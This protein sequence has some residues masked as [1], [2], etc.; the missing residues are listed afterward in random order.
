M[1][2]QRDAIA[3]SARRFDT[4]HH[5]NH[6]IAGRG[7]ALFPRERFG[8][9]YRALERALGSECFRWLNGAAWSPS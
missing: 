5:L 3:P 4:G 2:R 9:E 6:G 1:R 7:A 8:D